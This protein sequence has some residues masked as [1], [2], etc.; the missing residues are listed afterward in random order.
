MYSPD[1]SDYSSASFPRK[2]LTPCNFVAPTN[3]T[4]LKSLPLQYCWRWSWF[5]DH[6][7]GIRIVV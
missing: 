4:S 6:P 1:V 3:L 5:G 2:T 7:N